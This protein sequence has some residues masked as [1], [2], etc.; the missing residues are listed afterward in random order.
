MIIVDIETTKFFDHPDVARLPRNRQLD[1]IPFGLAV[2]YD[3]QAEEY[4]LWSGEVVAH[5]LWQYLLNSNQVI[6]GWNIIRFDIPII[7]RAAAMFPGFVP[8][9]TSPAVLDLFDRIIVHTHRWYTL[10]FIAEVNGLGGKSGDG[11]EAS[12]W[13]NSGDA[14]LIQRC[15]EYCKRDVYLTWQLY[16]MA[17]TCGLYLPAR[18]GRKR[19][20]IEDFRI[21]IDGERWRLVNEDTGDDFREAWDVNN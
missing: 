2:T 21:W 1:A 20:E 13:L 14:A 9:L 15:A 4:I 6:G 12:E 5:S 18:P 11:R 16:Q 7:Q 8:G 10:G 19:P 17:A 3:S